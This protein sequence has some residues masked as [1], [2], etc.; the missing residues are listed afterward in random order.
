M[1]DTGLCESDL[2]VGEM[3][4]VEL[5]GCPVLIVRHEQGVAA[6]RDRCPHQGYPLSEGELSGGVITCRAHHHRFDAVSG[7]GINPPR[8]CLVRLK[9]ALVAGA[10][11]VEPG[12]PSRKVEP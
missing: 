4:G 8:P 7:D 3:R 6:Y 11:A 9:V 5:G 2:W 10:I 1:L 12:A